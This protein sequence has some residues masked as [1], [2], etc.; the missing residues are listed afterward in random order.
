MFDSN[1]NIIYGSAKTGKTMFLLDI[2]NVLKSLGMK[3]FFLGCTGEFED[4]RRNKTL[5][6]FDDIR[7][8]TTNNN[9]NNS[10]LIEVIKEITENNN[11]DYIVVDDSDF[12]SDETLKLLLDLKVKKIIT[13]FTHNIDRFENSSNL[14]NISHVSNVDD[15]IKSILREQKINKILK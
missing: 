4:F 11:Y 3:L 10:K 13:S 2:S 1:V 6:C 15:Y 5:S 9:L 12:L 8:T 14:F 7:I